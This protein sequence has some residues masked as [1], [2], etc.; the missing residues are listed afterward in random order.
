MLNRDAMQYSK[1]IQELVISPAN[2]KL[3]A[4]PLCVPGLH[5]SKIRF[6][7][8]LPCI[9][10][11][12]SANNSETCVSGDYTS[13]IISEMSQAYTLTWQ[14]AL[15]TSISLGQQVPW[16]ESFH[17]LLKTYKIQHNY[18]LRLTAFL[19]QTHQQL[20]SRSEAK[21]PVLFHR[22]FISW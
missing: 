2:F 6:L 8:I 15:K 1:A 12:F 7:L 21:P 13:C 4:A 16:L 14:V 11:H 3:R 9:Q 5:I 17:K 20:F 18:L 10:T 22:Q 19:Q